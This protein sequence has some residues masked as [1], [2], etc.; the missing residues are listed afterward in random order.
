MHTHTHTYWPGVIQVDRFMM[1]MRC[2]TGVRGKQEGWV[3]IIDPIHSLTW[4]KSGC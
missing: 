4:H 1:C 3:D 2:V